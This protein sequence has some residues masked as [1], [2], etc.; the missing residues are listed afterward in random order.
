MGDIEELIVFE[1]SCLL[2]FCVV[3]KELG[4]NKALYALRRGGCDE[5]DEI[6]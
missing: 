3:N 4:E 1:R 2:T 5:E 6:S